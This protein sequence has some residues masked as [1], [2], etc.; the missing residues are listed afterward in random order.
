MRRKEEEPVSKPEVLIITPEDERDWIKRHLD[1]SGEH[2]PVNFVTPEAVKKMME[3]GEKPDI[4]ILYIQIEGWKELT[5]Q[6]SEKG[7]K[8]GVLSV[9]SSMR[10][11]LDAFQNGAL[12][13]GHGPAE[14]LRE[15]SRDRKKDNL[16]L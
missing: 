5:K 1:N 15:L 7:T 12:A 3:G 9:L 16:P 2:Q 14:L 4:V 10:D 6:L 13:F 11:G 8:V